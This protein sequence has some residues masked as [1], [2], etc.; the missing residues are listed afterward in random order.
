MGSVKWKYDSEQWRCKS[1]ILE[2]KVKVSFSE[3]VS[4][5]HLSIK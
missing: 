4:T 1:V 3:I 2:G 5:L